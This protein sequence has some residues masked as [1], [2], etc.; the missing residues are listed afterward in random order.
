MERLADLGQKYYGNGQKDIAIKTWETGAEQGNLNCQ[1]HL[2]FTL[3]S[4]V[5][6]RRSEGIDWLEKASV[7]GNQEAKNVIQRIYEN[8][9]I[10]DSIDSV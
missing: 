4:Y 5:D 2:G 10:S 8:D 1:Y 3:Y 7:G 6:L 9:S